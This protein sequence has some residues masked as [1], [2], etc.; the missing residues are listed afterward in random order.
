MVYVAEDVTPTVQVGQ[1]VS[2]AT[3]I[4]N[5][6]DGGD[7][8]ETGWAQATGLS[9]ESQLPEAGGIGGGGPFPTMVGLSFDGLLQSL[10]VPPRPTATSLPPAFCHEL[11]RELTP[12]ESARG[13]PAESLLNASSSRVWRRPRPIVRFRSDP[14]G[15]SVRNPGKSDIRACPV[16]E[17]V[18]GAC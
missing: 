9:A 10:G 12:P 4:A 7:G 14:F 3:V 15:W 2:P 17:N 5:M 18:S 13:A 11:P 1:H 6:F 8:I 16:A